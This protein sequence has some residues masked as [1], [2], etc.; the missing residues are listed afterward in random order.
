[1]NVDIDKKIKNDMDLQT[2]ETLLCNLTYASLD[3]DDYDR[4]GDANFVKLFRLSQYS[5]EYLLYMQRYMESLC[6]TL[7]Q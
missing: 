1:M 3:R 7:D 5:V 6:Q 2:L 4:L